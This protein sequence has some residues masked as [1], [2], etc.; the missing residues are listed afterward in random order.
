MIPQYATDIALLPRQQGILERFVRSSTMK[1]RMAERARIVLMSADD[2]LCVEAAGVLG[3]D[4]QR[5]RQWRRRW[6]AAAEVLLSAE[7]QKVSSDELEQPVRHVLGDEHRSGMTPS[8]LVEHLPVKNT[9]RCPRRKTTPR[10]ADTCRWRS[11]CDRSATTMT[12]P[13]WSSFPWSINAAHDCHVK[14]IS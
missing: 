14:L 4:A 8:A 11:A 9:G 13:N 2:L 1:R 12:S 10:I 5:V 6:A 7:A 3:F